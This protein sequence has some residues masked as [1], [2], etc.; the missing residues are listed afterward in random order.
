[1][2]Y[3]LREDDIFPLEKWLVKP[4]P[5]KNFTEEY[6]IYNYI[7]SYC[8]RVIENAFGILSARWRIFQR[9]IR[10][11]VKDVE[12]YVLVALA[13]HNSLL[14]TGSASYTPNNFVDSEEPDGSIHLGE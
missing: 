13:L 7:L 4:Y 5:G 2:P 1:M 10:A 9:P 14:Q 6:K 12:Q 11:T 8:R 3:Y